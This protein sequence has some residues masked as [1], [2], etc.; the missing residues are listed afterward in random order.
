[1]LLYCRFARPY[2]WLDLLSLFMSLRTGVECYNVV[3]TILALGRDSSY[4]ELPFLSIHLLFKFVLGSSIVLFTHAL[5]FFALIWSR[6][7]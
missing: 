6:S 3:E 5:P 7:S 1:M 4:K 2:G